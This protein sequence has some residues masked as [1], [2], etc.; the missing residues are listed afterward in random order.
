MM[1]SSPVSIRL[2]VGTS[3]P[4]GAL[5]AVAL[6]AA[7]AIA[8]LGAVDAGYRGQQDVLDRPGQVP[9]EAGL[10][11]VAV[12]AEAH[13][14]P[15]FVRL[16]P[17]EAG[18]KPEQYHHEAEQE[19]GPA[20]GEAHARAAT[21]AEEAAHER[22]QA[23]DEHVDIG[24][25]AGTVRRRGRPGEGHRD[26]RRP[27]VRRHRR[28][29]AGAGRSRYR[30]R[31]EETPRGPGRYGPRWVRRYSL[32]R[33]KLLS[34][35]AP[36]TRHPRRGRWR[37]VRPAPYRLA[38]A[39]RRAALSAH[40]GVFATHLGRVSPGRGNRIA[41]W[42]PLRTLCARHCARS[43]TP[44]RGWISSAPAWWRASSCAPAWCRCRC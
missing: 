27:K 4:V 29:R 20:A 10:G 36:E 5:G 24:H 21:A 32:R 12:S 2:S 28:H 8:D 40:R 14:H 39:S 22:L 13:H 44:R 3:R 18:A 34:G 15:E 17:V 35:R 26:R 31:S 7:R 43:R 16:H 6:L 30:S 37:N 9:V 1:F 11:T 42:P 23:G 19:D 33:S 38:P 41:P 25:R